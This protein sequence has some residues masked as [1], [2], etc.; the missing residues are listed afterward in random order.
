MFEKSDVLPRDIK[1]KVGVQTITNW[2]ILPI[3]IILETSIFFLFCT[4]M[5][6]Q[7][8]KEIVEMLNPYLNRI[9]KRWYKNSNTWYAPAVSLSIRHHLS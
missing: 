2:I 4:K 3:Q 1:Y 6:M 5:R 8:Y 7:E 9:R